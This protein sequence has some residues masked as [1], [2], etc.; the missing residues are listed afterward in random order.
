[1]KNLVQQL[2]N[3][4]ETALNSWDY[5]ECGNDELEIRGN[6]LLSKVRKVAF[7]QRFDAENVYVKFYN[8]NPPYGFSYDSFSIYDINDHKMLYDV[9]PRSGHP[10]DYNNSI[11]FSHEN[12]FK[13]PLIVGSV[14]E[15][16]DY[17]E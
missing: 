9:T 17:F 2:R 12:N 7:S 13:E 15:V 6:I 10:C 11:L 14:K 3:S 5:Y 1:M 16:F 4:V 8:K